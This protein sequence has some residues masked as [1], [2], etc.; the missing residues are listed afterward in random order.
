[1]F[2]QVSGYR[3]CG[4]Q[5]MPPLG[6]FECVK[7]LEPPDSQYVEAAKG[8]CELHAFTEVDAELDSHLSVRVF[9]VRQPR[10]AG[11]SSRS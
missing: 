2:G 9:W 4:L 6:R 11:A 1:M 3:T 10:R 7:P 8:W 5:T